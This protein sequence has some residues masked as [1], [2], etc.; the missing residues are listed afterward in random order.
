MH[1][2]TVTP[3]HLNL[4]GN[5]ELKESYFRVMQVSRYGHFTYILPRIFFFLHSDFSADCRGGGLRD[6]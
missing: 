1:H 6:G 3:A 4:D 5:F 2:C